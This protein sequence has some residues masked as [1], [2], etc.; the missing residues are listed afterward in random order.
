MT[1]VEIHFL[2]L[3][4]KMRQMR[5]MKYVSKT[6]QMKYVSKTRQME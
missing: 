5:Q 4:L 2:E 6:R 1:S 3:G